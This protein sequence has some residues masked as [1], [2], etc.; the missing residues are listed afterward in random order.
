[1]EQEQDYQKMVTDTKQKEEE[2]ENSNVQL[3]KELSALKANQVQ[4]AE[5]LN[6]TKAVVSTIWSTIYISCRRCWDSPFEDFMW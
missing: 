6:S 3:S 1:M 5:Q 4:L 2:L